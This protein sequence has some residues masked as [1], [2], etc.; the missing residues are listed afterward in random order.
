MLAEE[1]RM[2][3]KEDEKI[4]IFKD[5]RIIIQVEQLINI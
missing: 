4:E 1:E 2:K 3:K 5:F